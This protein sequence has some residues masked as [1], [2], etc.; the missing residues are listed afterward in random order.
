[1]KCAILNNCVVIMNFHESRKQNKPCRMWVTTDRSNCC[2]NSVRS[3]CRW[4]FPPELRIH[5]ADGRHAKVSQSSDSTILT[6]GSAFQ[7]AGRGYT[8]FVWYLCRQIIENCH[9]LILMTLNGILREMIVMVL[10]F[11]SIVPKGIR[12]V[13]RCVW[14]ELREELCYNIIE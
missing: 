11:E 5:S 3:R 4:S 2:S 6:G 1:M 9:Q 8:C 12:S 7:T 10:S 13:S 14:K